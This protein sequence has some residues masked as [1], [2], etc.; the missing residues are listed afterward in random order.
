MNGS[1]ENYYILTDVV[2]VYS[3][4]LRSIFKR[5]QTSVDHRRHYAQNAEISWFIGY[6]PLVTFHEKLNLK[7]WPMKCYRTLYRIIMW[8]KGCCAH[9][10]TDQYFATEIEPYPS[11]YDVNGMSEELNVN[12]KQDIL[13]SIGNERRESISLSMKSRRRCSLGFVGNNNYSWCVLVPLAQD[14]NSTE[15]E[16]C[17]IMSFASSYMT[18]LCIAPSPWNVNIGGCVWW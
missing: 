18:L 12:L 14:I 9:S 4:I 13:V 15:L 10:H 3:C 1:C 11:Q 5:A 6:Y 2:V 17:F 7:S 8:W 16:Y